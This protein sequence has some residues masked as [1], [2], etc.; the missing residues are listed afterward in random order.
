MSLNCS[1]KD[2]RDSALAFI[3]FVLSS[4]IEP[5]IFSDSPFSKIETPAFL[6]LLK[7]DSRAG[8]SN[9]LAALSSS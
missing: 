3:L 8:A 2:L 1:F 7:I 4:K 6:I 5:S 9:S